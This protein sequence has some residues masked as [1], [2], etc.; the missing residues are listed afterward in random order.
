MLE[1]PAFFDEKWNKRAAFPSLIVTNR[2]P[3]N[4]VSDANV[5]EKGKVMIFPLA[6]VYR[7]HKSIAGFL[8]DLLNALKQDDTI[9]AL[10]N[11]DGNNL[12]KGWSW[13][14]RY[15]KMEPGF[16][17]FNL[18]LNSAIKDLLAKSST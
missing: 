10:D 16:F 5:L 6:D 17:V 18:K 9:E 14:S 1:A 15:F 13:L 12:Q 8:T 4:A 7:E 11:L 3:S 2:V